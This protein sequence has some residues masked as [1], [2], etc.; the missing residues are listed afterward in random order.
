MKKIFTPA[1]AIF[2]LAAILSLFIYACTKPTQGI[3][4]IVK[5]D[6]LSKSPTLIQ[7]TNANPAGTTLPASMSVTVT[8]PLGVVQTDDGNTKTFTAFNG[9]LPLSLSRFSSPSVKTPVSFTIAA[10]PT[11]FIPVINTINITSDTA[12]T[13]TVVPLIEYAHPAGGTAALQK[14]TVLTGGTAPLTSLPLPAN[15]TTEASTVTIPAGTQMKDKNG[16]V[17]NATTL[18]SKIVYL[19]TTASASYNAFPGGFNPK[20]VIGPDG[21]A[22]TGGVTFIT[23]GYISMDLLANTTAVKSFSKPIIVN[24]EIN[25]QLINPLTGDKVKVGDV[26]PVWSY[27]ETVGQWKYESTTAVIKNTD[28]NLAANMSV[29]HLTGWSLDWYSIACSSSLAVSVSIPGLTGTLDDYVLFLASANEQYLGGLFLNGS[30]SNTVSLSN[31]FKGTI[32]NLPSNLGSV[33]VVVYAKKG[34]ATSKMFE[35]PLFSPCSKGSISVS[36]P[37]PVL[38]E[39]IKTHITTIAKCKT[40]QVVAY[41]TAWINITDVTA[42]SISSVYMVNGVVDVKLI[43]GHSYTIST[44]YNG[45]NFASGSFKIDKTTNNAIPAG[46][47]LSGTVVYDSATQVLNVNAGFTLSTCG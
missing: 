23:A 39:L 3:D 15:G 40:Q 43:S 13:V 33:K 36:F 45:K 21:S 14:S 46:T 47:G 32:T 10:A 4:L 35:S 2:S 41:P 11:G 12:K 29:T 16:A 19:G 22:I 20:N 1:I 8:D 37:S 34:D 44:S 7:Y 28:G 31:G 6:A 9:F 18:S 5:T 30:W 27:D 25:P 26:I 24:M 42:A 38:P 17:I